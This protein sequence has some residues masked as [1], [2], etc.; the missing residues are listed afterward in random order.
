MKKRCSA[1]SFGTSLHKEERNWKL[2]TLIDMTRSLCCYWFLDSCFL[3]MIT[4][5]HP[6]V[7][8]AMR[9]GA[10]WHILPNFKA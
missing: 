8:I 7:A 5:G 4:Y 9:K 3:A 10:Q 6:P 1:V 2:D